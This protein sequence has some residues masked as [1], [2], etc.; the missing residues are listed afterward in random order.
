MCIDAEYAPD[1][2]MPWDAGIEVDYGGTV[3]MRVNGKIKSVEPYMG[4][5][6]ALEVT[7]Y[8]E[9]FEPY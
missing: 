4:S 1:L 5:S 6:Y 9:S 8:V 7:L 3:A 2:V